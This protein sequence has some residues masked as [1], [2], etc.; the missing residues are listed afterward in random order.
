MGCTIMQSDWQLI[1]LIN[2]GTNMGNV[3]LRFPKYM[4]SPQ[5]FRG[6]VPKVGS[7]TRCAVH[8]YTHRAEVWSL[9]HFCA[10][11]GAR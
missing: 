5:N 1:S 9:L 10:D 2:E 4:L 7:F 8:Q 6:V 11:M 3:R